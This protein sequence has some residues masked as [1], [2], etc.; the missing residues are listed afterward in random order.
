LTDWERKRE[1][2]ERGRQGGNIR[3]L[4]LDKVVVDLFSVKILI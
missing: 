3:Q 2:G 4:V 1:T